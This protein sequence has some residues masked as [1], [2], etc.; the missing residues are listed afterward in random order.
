MATFSMPEII[1]K[2]LAGDGKFPGDPQAYAIYEYRHGYTGGVLW[3]V[4]WNPAH[5][6]LE[7]N[8]MIA[9]Y[10]LLWSKDAGHVAEI[11]ILDK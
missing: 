5:I 10:K 7:G 9:E 4:F 2:M 8:R 3:A 11:G 1:E 6:D